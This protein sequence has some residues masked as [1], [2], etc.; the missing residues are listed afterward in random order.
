MFDPFYTTKGAGKGTG[1]GLSIVHGIV[2][3]SGGHVA[4]DSVVGEGTAI[5]V[6]LPRVSG[7]AD[8]PEPAVEASGAQRAATILLVE[9][10]PEVLAFAGKALG[11]AGH[12]VVTA[13]SGREA[14]ETLD[15]AAA[16]IDLVLTDVIM[17]GMSGAA[18]AD[19][20]AERHPGLPVM[21]MS[22]YTYDVL[23]PR[24][25]GGGDRP[26]IHKPFTPAEL[27]HEVEAVLRAAPVR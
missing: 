14:V 24:G 12:A 20:V 26:L 9:D 27:V 7:A 3:Q 19:H 25:V 8:E 13:G 1:L 11:R 5:T 16:A 18:L 4:V 6:Y 22:G 2:R 21:Y 15:L 23:G 10:E 17:P